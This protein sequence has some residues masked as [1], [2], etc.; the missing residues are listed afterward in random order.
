MDTQAVKEFI[1]KKETE[2]KNIDK[3]RNTVG[4]YSAGFAGAF[5]ILGTIFSPLF[6]LGSIAM[7]VPFIAVNISCSR[8]IKKLNN[9]LVFAKNLL[10][11]VEISE[12]KNTITDSKILEYL[13]DANLVEMSNSNIGSNKELNRNTIEKNK[14]D[15]KNNSYTNHES[16][17]KTL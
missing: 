11:Q 1:V 5:I 10:K 17:E 12:N 15:D 16:D 8:H 6:M 2:I 13:D 14:I 9:N 7:L 4:L 3:A